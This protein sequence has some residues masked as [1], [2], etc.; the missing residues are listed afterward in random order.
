MQKRLFVFSEIK[1]ESVG[2][3]HI[4]LLGALFYLQKMKWNY[5]RKIE[6]VFPKVNK[7]R[8]KRDS[9]RAQRKV[10]YNSGRK[11]FLLLMYRM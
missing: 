9:K 1:K 6:N 4:F 10:K 2:Q 7:V 5:E 3:K 8:R 11:I